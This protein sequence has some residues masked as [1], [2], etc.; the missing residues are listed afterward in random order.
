MRH[1]LVRW[2]CCGRGRLRHDACDP[3]RGR[4]ARDP[5]LGRGPGARDERSARRGLARLHGRGLDQ[6]NV[7]VGAHGGVARRGRGAAEHNAD[8][9]LAAAPDGGGQVEPG[10][11]RVAGLEAV[12]AGIVEQQ[13]VVVAE[14]LVLVGERPRGKQRVL[15]GEVVLQVQRQGDHVACR[16]HLLVVGQAGGIP[17]GRGS[18]AELTRLLGHQLCELLLAAGD[19]LGDRHRNVVGALGDQSLDGLDEGDL[20]AGLEIELGWRGSRRNRG[21]ADLGFGPEGPLL[22]PLEDQIEGHQLGQGRRVARCVGGLLAQHP[23]GIDVEHEHGALGPGLDAGRGPRRRDDDRQKTRQCRS[24][25]QEPRPMQLKLKD[26]SLYV[27]RPP[28]PAPLRQCPSPWATPFWGVFEAPA[29][30][31][32]ASAC[33]AESLTRRP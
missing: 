17:K 20:L 29:H 25:L 24:H 22:H 11:A 6:R 13:R 23:A 32:G 7:E 27:Q 9:V 33:S 31:W 28:P 19:V 4:H 14:R 8:D 3:S 12:R 30:P 2:Q 26:H 16:R 21:H 1:R 15:P 18:H 5:G 10:G